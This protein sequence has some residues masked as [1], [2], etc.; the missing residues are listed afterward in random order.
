[1]VKYWYIRLKL[2]KCEIADIPEKFRAEVI[3]L[4]NS[5]KNS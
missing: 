2:G 3:A 1:M 5:E 4:K